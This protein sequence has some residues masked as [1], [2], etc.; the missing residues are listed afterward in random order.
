MPSPR[1]AWI[2]V[3]AEPITD[4]DTTAADMLTTS[5]DLN[6]RRICLV[7]AEMKDPVRSKI[8]RYELFRADDD[9]RFFPTIT[10]AVKAF[11]RETGASWQAPET[12][13]DQG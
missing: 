1:P 5:S 3:A 8:D 13:A 11:Q 2:V 10:Q 6:A 12:P 7:F 4:V 9:V